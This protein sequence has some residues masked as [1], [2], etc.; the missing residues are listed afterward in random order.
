MNDSGNAIEVES[1]P[2]PAARRPSHVLIV[3]DNR[4]ILK[5][6]RRILSSE[7]FEVSEAQDGEEALR[8]ARE[9]QPDLLLLDIMLPK[10]DGL[11][12][13]RELKSDPATR[14]IMVIFVTGRISVTQRVEGFEAGA[15]D[16]IPKPFH[17][18]E[19]LAR[20]RTALRLK[21]LTDDLEERNLQLVKSQNDLVRSEKMATIGLLASGIAHEFNNIMAGISGYAQLARMNPIHHDALVN[22]ALTQTARA[23]ELTRSLSTYNHIKNATKHCSVG[24]VLDDVLCLVS[25]EAQNRAIRISTTVE[26]ESEAQ[27]GPGPLQEVLLNLVL[28]AVQAIDHEDGRIR[29][30]VGPA[31]DPNSIEIEVTDNGIG[32]AAKDIPNLFDPF[33]TT[34]GAFGGGAESGTGLGL[35]VCY[36]ILNSHGGRIKVTSTPRES[37]S[38]LVSLPRSFETPQEKRKVEATGTT[39]EPT[40]VKRLRILVVDDES[41]AREC[42]RSFLSAHEVVCCSRAESGIEAY[43]IEPFDFVILDVCLPGQEN[44]FTAFD[45][46]H[47]FDPP[48]RIIFASGRFPDQAFHDYIRRA[49]G[50]LLKPF[51][52]ENLARLLGISMP[53]FATVEAP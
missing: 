29:I 30:R 7:E 32:I 26:N 9:S 44:G 6:L 12:V 14:G 52:F 51:K 10:K 5:I 34:K 38:F 22:V 4:N 15:D 28:N 53:S 1:E 24:T 25:K 33:F 42:L 20:T 11:E 41:S 23:L 2:S 3:D 46:F 8:I 49:H 21:R 13:C 17:V 35:T 16:Y 43:A 36:N 45:R 40:P 27:I 47:R 50:Y 48:P 18:R 37:T 19:L 31:P 39:A